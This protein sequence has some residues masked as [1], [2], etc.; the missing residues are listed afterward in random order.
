M[1]AIKDSV[2][3]LV[4][5]LAARSVPFLL[6]P[7]L[8]RK[9]GVEGFGQL[10]YFQA[11]LALFTIFISLSQEGAISRYFYF[12][13]KR[14]L[15]LVLQT[16]HAYSFTIGMLVLIG[17][18]ISNTEI[19]AIVAL[20]CLFQSFLNVQLTVRQCRKQAASYA[21]I[22]LCSTL[23]S[24]GLTILFLEIFQ[25]DLVQKRLLAILCSNIAVFS[26]AYLFY[27][28]KIQHKKFAWQQYK[29]AF[30]YLLGFGLPLILH[31]SSLFLRG[32]F[33]RFLINH[34]FSQAELGLYAMG[35]QMA[36]ILTIIIQ[37]LNK[38]LMPY[39]FEGLK[40]ERIKIRHIHQWAIYSLLFIPLPALIMWLIPESW[41]VW[42]LGEQFAG[43][44]HY[45]VLFLISSALLIPYLILVNYLFYF[46]KNKQIAFCS[47]TGTL[48]Y[49]VSLLLLIQTQAQYVPFASIIG[50]LVILP[51]LYI[52]TKKV[53]RTL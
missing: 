23:T 32:Q 45:I 31:N 26:L 37:V 7:Y 50:A 2:I 18:W 46:G 53:S 29:M 48:L 8:S 34:Q 47:V 14:S 10:S 12:Y 49:L 38:A 24:A 30:F 22:Q 21:M 39:L 20:S 5:E 33:D 13:G 41:V 25:D 19:L 1:R 16:G 15:N 42:V 4:G 27:A 51:I 40:Q 9:L 6:L 3:Y 52:M 44:K 35:L 43:T 11:W 36:S 17:C 28:K